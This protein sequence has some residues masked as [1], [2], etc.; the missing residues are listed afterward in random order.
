MQTQTSK[1]TIWNKLMV[2]AQALEYSSLDYQQDQLIGLR[3]E[4]SELSGR[5]DIIERVTAQQTSNIE[6]EP[7][8]ERMK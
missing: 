1:L 6:R 5:V 2:W 7:V 8:L 4:L 3:S